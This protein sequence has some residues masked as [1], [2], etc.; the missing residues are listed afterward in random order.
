MPTS[1]KPH[2]SL[3]CGL[4]IAV[5]SPAAATADSVFIN[6]MTNQGSAPNENAMDATQAIALGA[7]AFQNVNVQGTGGT[8]PQP[9]NV[10][11]ITGGVRYAD[12]WQD[13]IKAALYNGGALPEQ[14]FTGGLVAINGTHAGDNPGGHSSTITLDLSDYLTGNGF[15][16]YRLRIFY[17]GRRALGQSALTD[18][19]NPVVNINDGITDTADFAQAGLLSVGGGSGLDFWSG[20]GATRTFAATS[21][22]ITTATVAGTTESGIAGILILPPDG[23]DPPVPTPAD[24]AGWW[25][26]NNAENLTQSSFGPDLIVAGT[27][28]THQATRADNR[29]DPFTLDGVITTTANTGNHLIAPHSIGANGGGSRVNEYTLLFD[30]L[31]P[32]TS[33]WRCFYQTNPANTSDGAYFV[34]SSDNALGR[35]AITYGPAPATNQWIRLVISADLKTGGHFRTYIDGQLHHIHT[36]PGVDSAFSLDPSSV[37][38]FADDNNENQPLVISSAAIFSKA[39]DAAEV[40]ALGGPGI[41]LI[42]PPGNQQPSVASQPAGPAT[43]EAGDATVYT[44]TPADPDGDAVQI[45]ADWGDGTFS[46]WS[47]FGASGDARTITANWTNPGIYQIRAR[48]R[49]IFGATSEWVD[50]QQVTVTGIP[51]LTFRTPPYLQNMSTTTMVV[52]A[53]IEET[54]PLVLQYGQTES[55]GSSVSMDAVASGGGSFFIRGTLTGLAPGTTHHYRIATTTGEGVTPTATFRTAPDV[56]EDFTFTSIGDVQTTNRIRTINTWAWEADAWE[57]AKM[58]LHHMTTRGPRFLLGLGDHADDG[59]SYARTRLSHLDRTAAIF[60][61]YAPFFIGWGNHDGNNPSHPL[62]L[63]ADMP[64]RWRTDSLSTFTSGFGSFAFEYSG[65]F[66]VC[67]EHFNAFAGTHTF[68]NNAA[69][70]DIMNGWL[71]AALSSPAARNA[72]FRIV[73]VHVPPYCERWIT[74]NAGLR[75]HLVPR[76]EQHNVDLCMSG[77][78]HGYERGRINGVQYVISGGGSYLDIGEPLVANWSSTTD[79]GLWLG[80]HVDIPGQYAMQSS[81]G[82]LGPPQPVEG[83]LFHGYSELTVRDRHITLD[84]HAFNADGSYI[85]ILDTISI[86]EPDPG[87][88]SNG[89]GMRDQWKIAN[90]LDPM[91]TEGVNGPHYL[92]P[93]GMTNLQHYLAGTDPLSTSPAFGML[94]PTVDENGI[95]LSWKSVPGVR[96]RIWRSDD[97]DGWNLVEESPG[98]PLVLVADGPVTSHALPAAPHPRGFVRVEA[99]R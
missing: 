2:P 18:A 44:F 60:G 85:G 75:T 49:D 38:L 54:T 59:N 77:H 29:P 19:G 15:S 74:G 22:T 5:L 56:W 13:G 46:D 65:L 21:L 50:I 55:L 58:M 91:S 94:A 95:D 97:L 80:G 53:E 42:A 7:E 8:Q 9:I 89:D 84:Q 64:S 67:I 10:A 4:M 32:G 1:K 92:R 82:V 24:L 66:I 20:Q 25:E 17:A 62:R 96:Y 88:D 35:A 6:F 26:F 52:M 12:W 36:K 76:L 70:N 33:Q 30:V 11:G 27:P 45:Q 31:I 73:V 3:L 93:N 61:T 40:A 47:A 14:G 34:R 28:P 79:D 98:V 87:P 51:Q 78:M 81:V 72:R 39:L 63:S 48:S 43:T 16:E 90:G 71:D 99:I 37:L 41:R 57:P 86:G 68:N 69:T 83:G 23:E